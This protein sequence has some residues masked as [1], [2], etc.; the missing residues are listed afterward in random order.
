MTRKRYDSERRAADAYEALGPGIPMT[1]EELVRDY[2][3]RE[4]TRL[5]GIRTCDYLAKRATGKARQDW[6]AIANGLRGTETPKRRQP[7]NSANLP[8][9]GAAAPIIGIIVSE[10]SAQTLVSV[11]QIYGP[12]K[13]R[14]VTRARNAVYAR[15]LDAGL[16]SEQVARV[17]KREASTVRWCA[18]RAR[19]NAAKFERY[20]ELLAA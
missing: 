2:K 7:Y 12:L 15:A 9:E 20:A 1:A 16:S 5:L 19:E 6:L 3:V 14:D 18:K 10:I 11:A 13:T 17:M 4:G 8:P